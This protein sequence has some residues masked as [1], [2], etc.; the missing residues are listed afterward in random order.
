VHRFETLAALAAELGE[1]AE[2][3]ADVVNVGVA[4][5]LLADEYELSAATVRLSQTPGAGSRMV[6]N[7]TQPPARPLELDT[8]SLHGPL[9]S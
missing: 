5:G 8:E 1:W 7:L 2:I 9:P 4:E 6:T 3:G